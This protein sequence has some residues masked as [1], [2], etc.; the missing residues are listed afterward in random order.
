MI[1][2]SAG[3]IRR[4]GKFLL[5]QRNEG[6]HQELLWEFPGGKRELNETLE[7]CLVREVQEELAVE[8]LPER[9]LESQDC[10]YPERT[11]RLFF[12]LCQ[13]VSGEPCCL[14]CQDARWVG[15][16]ELANLQFLPNDR[17]ILARLIREDVIGT[18]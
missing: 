11:I 14:D 8:I 18:Y 3:V 15:A 9:L 13:W 17:D 5:C 16:P 6:A 12:Y 2:V 10:V 1:V 4:G 7:D